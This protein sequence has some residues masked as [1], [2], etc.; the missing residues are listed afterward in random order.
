MTSACERAR[1]DRA[2][3]PPWDRLWWATR[4]LQ[5]LLFDPG[6]LG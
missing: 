2:N 3:L 4:E 1:L 5:N 6:S